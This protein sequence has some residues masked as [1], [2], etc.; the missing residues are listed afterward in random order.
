MIE[1]APLF[2]TVRGTLDVG[3]RGSCIWKLDGSWLSWNKTMGS[4]FPGIYACDDGVEGADADREEPVQSPMATEGAWDVPNSSTTE[5]LSS[6]DILSPRTQIR[7]ST[8]LQGGLEVVECKWGEKLIEALLQSFENLSG[9]GE[10]RRNP[11]TSTTNDLLVKVNCVGT[12]F[13]LRC[14]T[15]KR[16]I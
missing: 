13:R 6:V 11:K 14:T 7:W 2:S 8:E 12:L 16:K 10:H 15:A 5:S 4:V 1:G 3:E 9:P